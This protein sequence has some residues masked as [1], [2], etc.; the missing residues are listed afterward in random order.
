MGIADT[1]RHA[2]LAAAFAILPPSVVAARAFAAAEVMS[3]WSG[4]HDEVHD[5]GVDQII[6]GG[7]VLP[8][9]MPQ[10]S[11]QRLLALD[12]PVQWIHGNGDREVAARLAGSEMDWYRTAPDAWREPVR[13]TAQQLPP[14]QAS[15]LAGWPATRRL[16][17]P[18]LG[19]VIFCHAT[20]RNDTEC[21]TRLTSAHRLIPI[22]GD[23]G[24]ALVV[25]GH[26]HM[27]FDRMVGQVRVVN[28]G[29]IGMP[30]G[31]P[32]ADWLIL[33]PDMELRHTTYDLDQAAERI[34]ATTYPQAENFAA[35][36]VLH[37]PSGE[38]ML[39]AF[40]RAELQ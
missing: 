1:L 23:C 4:D 18:G 20:L 37:P 32:G 36:H 7:D 29:S 11:L 40:S 8:G 28:A 35:R 31:K 5:A 12:T 19:E 27:P 6:V 16:D 34:R 17:I 22:F 14:A 10:E 25:C 15:W 13:W 39:E 2:V 3:Y 24:A 30:F 9:P 33:V 26:T 21:F 38:E